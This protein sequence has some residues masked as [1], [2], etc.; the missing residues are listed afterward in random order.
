[1]QDLLRQRDEISECPNQISA[2]QKI[3]LHKARTDGCVH[4][5]NAIGEFFNPHN[6]FPPEQLP[7]HPSSPRLVIIAPNMGRWEVIFIA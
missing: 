3:R 1:V 6:P 7:I 4:L 5:Y 2:L